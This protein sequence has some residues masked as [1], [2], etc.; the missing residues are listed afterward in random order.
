MYCSKCGT[1]NPD[2][3]GFCANC[4]EVFVKPKNKPDAP[5]PA[6]KRKRLMYAAIAGGAVMLLAIVLVLIFSGNGAK[7]A[8]KGLY[9]DVV[10]L[11]LNGV[12][13]LL[14]PA[15]MD[16]LEDSLDFAHSEFEIVETVELSEE[17]VEGIDTLYGIEFGTEEGYVEAATVVYVKVNYHGEELSR[18]P[19][20]LVMIQI[21]GDW[22][23]DILTTSEELDEADFIYDFSKMIP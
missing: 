3:A 1:K 2:G 9:R 4:G 8:V 20:P 6:I 11:D 5:D 21:D 18:D 7:K 19:I 15:A 12:A 10:D 16:Y 13:E 14:P 22:Y 17:R 23:L